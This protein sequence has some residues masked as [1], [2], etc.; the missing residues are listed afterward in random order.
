MNFATRIKILP[1]TAIDNIFIDNTKLSSSYITP[2][3]NSLSD[4]DAKFLTVNNFTTKVNLIA[5]KQ[6][7]RKINN[8][9][10]A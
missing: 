9:T 4:H 10:I 1:S 2:L 6:R 5:L 3:V 7:T 8:E